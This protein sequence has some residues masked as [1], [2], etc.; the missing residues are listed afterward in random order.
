MEK[1][2]RCLSLEMDRG[3]V[4]AHLVSQKK[5]TGCAIIRHS[6]RE[7]VVAVFMVLTNEPQNNF[8]QSI[9][10]FFPDDVSLEDS[11]LVCTQTGHEICNCDDPLFILWLKVDPNHP[12]AVKVG[13]YWDNEL[14]RDQGMAT[15]MY[16]Q[17]EGLLSRRGFKYLYGDNS[18]RNIGFFLQKQKRV[19]AAA[20]PEEHRKAVFD[21]GAE[22]PEYMTVKILGDAS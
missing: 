21:D 5:G 9:E 12:T 2:S 3:E 11:F 10:E 15:H 16:A 14:Y 17:L 7:I 6:R 22:I 13:D 8:L 20:L 4:L 19:L 18:E 1:E